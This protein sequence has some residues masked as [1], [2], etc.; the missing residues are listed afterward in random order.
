MSNNTVANGSAPG[1][2]A[3]FLNALESFCFN[4]W[5]DS[6]ITSNGSGVMT[7]LG[8]TVN[9]P[10]QP[11]PT[12]VQVTGS[13]SG[14]C[15]LYQLFT[16]TVKK[17]IVLLSNYKSGAAQ[18]MALPVAFTSESYWWTTEFQSGQ[19]E[20]LSGGSAQTFSVLTALAIGGGTQN[21][22]TSLKSWSQGMLRTA[23]DT[24]RITSLTTAA[25]SVVVIEGI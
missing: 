7:S 5:F 4:G 3:A 17:I 21:P 25:S 11:N 9:G 18:S 13:V 6:A 12:G 22:Q 14:T 19:I 10:I 16:G 8:Q 20:G 23:F 2:S 24:V 1:I 15:T